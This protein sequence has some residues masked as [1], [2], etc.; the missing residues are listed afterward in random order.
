MLLKK[1]LVHVDHLEAGE[2]RLRG[3]ATVA[4]LFDA[5]VNA[6]FVDS[7]ALWAS[8]SVY[9]PEITPALIESQKSVSESQQLRAKESF[10]RVSASGK[11]PMKWLVNEGDPAGRI[12]ANARVNDLIVMGAGTGEY[13]TGPGLLNQVVLS[14]GRPVLLLPDDFL[15]P[16]AEFDFK[17]IFIGWNNSREAAR[18]ISDALPF[19]QRADTVLIG[20]VVSEADERRAAEET[21][22]LLEYLEAHGLP[23]QVEIV[24]HTPPAGTGEVLLEAAT[25]KQADM[26][27][28]GAYGHSRW[29][30]IVLGG[31][32]RH[33]L[34]HANLPVL[35]SH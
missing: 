6:L 29:R 30:E 23:V 22:Q 12:C 25:A 21:P 4:G 19:L 18:A 9:G 17:R 3:G 11:V 14:A 1:V 10:D 27:V 24:S 15:V 20:T 13:L 35:M 28:M 26:L 31:T 7:W 16:R 34:K 32:T 5:S 2:R 33:V 8:A